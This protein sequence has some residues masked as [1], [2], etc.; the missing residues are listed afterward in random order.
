MSIVNHYGMYQKYSYDTGMKN[1]KPK[2]ASATEQQGSTE[3]THETEKESGS[4]DSRVQL[5]E[6]AKKLLEE[7]QT[8]YGNM[9]FFIADYHSEEEAQSYL[10]K[11]TKE[12]SVLIDPET[13]E[14]MAKDSETKEKYLG[15]LEDATGKLSQMKEGL[16]EEEG[17]VVKSLGISIDN[18][19]KVSYFAEL[20]KMSET[21]KEHIQK[22]KEDAETQ[23]EEERKTAQ[24]E[25]Q[26]RLSNARREKEPHFP[27]TTKKVSLQADSTEDLLEQIRAVDWSQIKATE[28]V[29][30]G[31]KFDFS[32]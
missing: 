25:E 22:S 26:E 24:K 5:S 18:D 8:T 14:K 13:L 28:Q 29:N 21:R 6:G 30:T 15:V 11:G 12:Y 16:S 1:R 2:D 10:S 31:T 9:D 3:R 20:E 27:R 7:L 23:A 4:V 32:V 17:S 19:G